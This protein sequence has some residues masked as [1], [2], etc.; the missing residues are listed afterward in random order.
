MAKVDR[1]GHGG[2]E[3][4]PALSAET[5]GGAAHA[6]LTVA[7]AR[8]NIQV[9]HGLASLLEFSE[10]PEYSFWLN[11]TSI[12]RL[13]EKLGDD[14]EDWI[15]ERIPLE[16]TTTNNPRTGRSVKRYWVADAETWDEILAEYDGRRKKATRGAQGKK[17]AKRTRK[18]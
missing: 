12:N 17:K 7:D 4:K 5:L 13:C 3:R 6:V 11:V 8:V 18:K 9:E 16:L 14:S 2:G 1:E 15:D 10:F